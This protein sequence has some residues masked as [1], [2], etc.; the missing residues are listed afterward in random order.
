V[1]ACQVLDPKSLTAERTRLNLS[2]RALERLAKVSAR[3]ILRFERVGA[4]SRK[5]R[6]RLRVA[7]LSDQHSITLA[8][9]SLEPGSLEERLEIPYEED[10]LCQDA[11]RQHPDGM[12]RE[13]VAKYFGIH[14][15]TVE[16]IEASALAKLHEIGAHIG[17]LLVEDPI[18]H[19][20]HALAGEGDNLADDELPMDF[21]RP[22]EP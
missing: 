9:L 18:H 13:Q 6:E 19:D 22:Y 11:V 10:E 15:N 3:S 2:L 21:H 8:R 4:I 5:S 7:L 14:A 16:A 1:I 20:V 17:E 12:S